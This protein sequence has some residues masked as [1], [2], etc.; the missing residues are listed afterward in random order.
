MNRNYNK[1]Q[2]HNVLKF[3][4]WKHYTFLFSDSCIFG[5]VPLN[6]RNGRAKETVLGKRVRFV[7][8]SATVHELQVV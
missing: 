6:S 7:A 1:Y 5:A 3:F 2:A 8:E 4:N